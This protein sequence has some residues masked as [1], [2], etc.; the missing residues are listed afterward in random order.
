MVE[1]AL[2]LLLMQWVPAARVFGLAPLDGAHWLLLAGFGPA[3]LLC[4]EAGKALWRWRIDA[5]WFRTLH[6][7]RRTP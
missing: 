5:R 7:F 3:L 6:R 2:L 1:V 4:E